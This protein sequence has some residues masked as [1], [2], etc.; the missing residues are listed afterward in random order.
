MAGRDGGA[1]AA[2]DGAFRI[3]VDPL[4]ILGRLGDAVSSDLDP[5]AHTEIG[6]PRRCAVTPS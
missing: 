6:A 5:A 4:P 1:V 3:D 2:A